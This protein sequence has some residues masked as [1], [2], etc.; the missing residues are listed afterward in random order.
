MK[1][2]LL[3]AFANEDEAAHCAAALGP[4][5]G[6]HISV[7]IDGATLHAD[8]TAASPLALLHTLDDALACLTAAQ[9]SARVGRR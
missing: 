6:S 2:Q 4:E 9:K 1:A 8:A 3:L 7:R 5:N